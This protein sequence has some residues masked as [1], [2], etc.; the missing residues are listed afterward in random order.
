MTSSE[1]ERST[2]Q[3]AAQIRALRKGRGIH[4]HDLNRKIGPDLRELAASPDGDTA[5]LRRVLASE[6]RGLAAKLPEDLCRVIVTSLGLSEHTRQMPLFGDRIAWLAEETRHNSRTILRW[7]DAAEQLLAEE[8]GSELRRRR[9]HQLA[10]TD[11]WYLDEFRAVLSLDAPSP[12]AHERRRIVATREGLSQVRASIDIPSGAD[13][14]AALDAKVLCGGR[15]V[16]KADPVANRFEFFIELPRPLGAGETH[17]YEMIVRIPPGRTMRP[18]YIFTPEYQ[19]N[20]FDLTVK[21]DLLQPPAWVRRVC[22]ET[23]R[24]F[25]GGGRAG[26]LVG[27]DSA[28]E[29]RMRVTNP[30]K[31]LGYGLQ[32]SF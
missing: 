9:S 27:L 22:A 15:L 10:A 32:W 3:V 8:I 16:R 12:E 20:V 19:C 28:G 25:D 30:E 5:D 31:Y 17:E 21:F 4:A 18:H 6:L 24:V 11:G 14:P 29:A 13:E 23:V 2:P 26:D 1:D 7:L